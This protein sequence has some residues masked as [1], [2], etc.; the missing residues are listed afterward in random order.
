[1][2]RI[3]P[4]CPLLSL[5]RLYQNKRQSIRGLGFFFAFAFATN[6]MENILWEVW[7]FDT[8]TRFAKQTALKPFYEFLNISLK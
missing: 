5:W 1:M 8:I 4:P 3:T 6:Q 2:L 7:Y